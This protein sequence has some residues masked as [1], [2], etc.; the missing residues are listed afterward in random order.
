MT[1]KKQWYDN[2]DLF[3]MIQDLR[4]ELKTTSKLVKEYNNLRGTLNDLIRR[5]TSMEE[6][7]AG[8][9]SVGKS[10]REWGGW[11]IGLIMFLITIYTVIAYG[12][13]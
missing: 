3:E 1:E 6:Q 2:K 8:R 12:V 5:V 13:R 10:I 9:H 7:A 11:I 4:D